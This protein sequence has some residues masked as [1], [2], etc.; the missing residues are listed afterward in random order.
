MSTDRGRILTSL[1]RGAIGREFGMGG[2]AAG[3]VAP[4]LAEPGAAF[5]T[6]TLGGQ[7]RGCIGS[8]EVHRALKDDVEANAM[9]AAFRDPRFPPL[10]AEEFR[11][12]RI[13]V[14]ELSPMTP[15]IFGS[16][17]EALAQ[18]RPFVDGVVFEYGRHRGTFLPQVW[19]QLPDPA[20]F[21]ARLKYK[22]GLPPNFWAPEVRLHRYT[23]AKWKEAEP[24]AP[25]SA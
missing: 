11:R 25:A 15:M 23:V 17:A 24:S 16:E 19:E 4:W 9:A 12:V 6:L 7:L 1:A 21:M 8:L 3:A 2:P 14:S 20:E 10:T 22:A 5:V 13:E 18:L